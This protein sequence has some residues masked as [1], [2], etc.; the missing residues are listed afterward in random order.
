MDPCMSV[1][2]GE[3]TSCHSPSAWVTDSQLEM[4]SQ[5]TPC[6]FHFHKF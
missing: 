1:C 5:T 2:E 4:H 6:A 3:D